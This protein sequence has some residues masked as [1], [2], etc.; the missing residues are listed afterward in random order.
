[1]GSVPRGWQEEGTFV[2]AF[3]LVITALAVTGLGR[4]WRERR[5]YALWLGLAF[6]F[7]L[8]WPTKWPQYVLVA[9]DAAVPV[10]RPRDREPAPAVVGAAARGGGPHR[11][12]AG[13]GGHA[14]AARAGPVDRPR[15]SGGR[16]RELRTAFPWLL[17]GII[18]LALLAAIP[19]AY[20]FLLS[21]T[22]MQLS[23]LKDGLNGGVL[24]ESLGGLTGQIPPASFDFDVSPHQVSYVGAD[25]LTGV[26]Q[27]V[28][29]GNQT[30]A[31]FIAFSVVWM[32]L[33]VGLQATLGVSV[34]LVLERPGMRF[35]AFWRTLFILP[36]AIP[37]VVGAVAWRDIVHPEQ[38]LL[39]QL[40]GSPVAGRRPEL[41]LLVLLVAGHLDGLPALDAGRDGRPADDPALG[42]RGRR[43]RRRRPLALVPERD[44]A[45][46]A[47]PAVGRVHR[48]G[49][50]H[51]QPVLPVL[52]AGPN[53]NTTTVSTF[54]YVLIR[55]Q[56]FF[57]R[58]AP[59]S[60]S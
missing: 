45:A 19:I 41:S 21:L 30:T 23:S 47:A 20:E 26:T 28:W 50:R 42:R 54:S 38:G 33:A 31:A 11:R 39:A 25:L 6:V 22:D 58:S 37:E 14:D 5:V 18:G 2:V 49:H 32:V 53:Q 57:T 40:M 9:V 7:L 44:A 16:L 55:D 46:A 3:D 34:A 52:G 12:R 29:L 4:L 10:G 17:P 15:R 51:V 24:R 1:M 13:R 56:P 60:T 43:D 35:T 48:P 8:A 36:W 59:R 27:G